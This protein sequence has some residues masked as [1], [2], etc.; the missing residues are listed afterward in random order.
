[1]KGT[2]ADSAALLAKALRHLETGFACITRQ[3]TIIRKL[4]LDGHPTE[5]A[6]QLLEVMFVSLDHMIEDKERIEKLLNL[7]MRLEISN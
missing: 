2:M 3:E 1:M 6:R 5:L 7:E 4:E